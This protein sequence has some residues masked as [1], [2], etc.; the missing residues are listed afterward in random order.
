VTYTNTSFFS[1]FLVG[2]LVRRLWGSHGS[3]RRV[4]RGG[5]RH[6]RNGSIVAQEQEAFLKPTVSTD[7]LLERSTSGDTPPGDHRGRTSALADV[8][9]SRIEGGLNV[10]ET[11]KLSLEF[12][13][14]WVKFLHAISLFA[15]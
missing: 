15:F 12:C 4:I 2:I 3:I 8:V 11:A 14:L 6:G 9:S 5:G 7:L 1:I 10:R 13:I